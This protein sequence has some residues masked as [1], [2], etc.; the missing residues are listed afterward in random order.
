MGKPRKSRKLQAKSI[1]SQA[2]DLG[3]P[4]LGVLGV[5]VK[6]DAPHDLS[7]EPIATQPPDKPEPR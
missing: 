7:A 4:V 5:V 1:A 6:T 2:A 3:R